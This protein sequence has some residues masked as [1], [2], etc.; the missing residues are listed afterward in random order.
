MPGGGLPLTIGVFAP[1]MVAVILIPAGASTESSYENITW[2]TPI[3]TIEGVN[4]HRNHTKSITGPSAGDIAVSYKHERLDRK[5]E[6]RAI[7]L[8]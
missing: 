1:Y 3:G 8:V 6:S 7:D 4:R 5:P 2:S